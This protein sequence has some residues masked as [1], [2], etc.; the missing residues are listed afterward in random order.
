MLIWRTSDWRRTSRISKPSISDPALGDI[1][2]AVEQGGQR[3]LASASGSDQGHGFSWSDVQ[4]D[5]LEHL[6]A[7]DVVKGDVVKADL[8]LD[9]RHLRRI[10]CVLDFG[11]D[12]EQLEDPHPRRHRPLHLAVLHGQLPDGLEEA[13]YPQRKGDQH[14]PL[15][16]ASLQQQASHQDDANPHANA[17]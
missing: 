10:G 13:L 8:A 16:L 1:G 9:R 5:V 4:V 6:D 15:D 7:W 17:G 2:E 3:A 11:L 12:I 14:T